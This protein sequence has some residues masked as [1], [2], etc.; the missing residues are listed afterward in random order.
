MEESIENDTVAHELERQLLNN[1][2]RYK[3]KTKLYENPETAICIPLQSND[4]YERSDAF[5]IWSCIY[6]SHL[7]KHTMI[8]LRINERRDTSDILKTNTMDVYKFKSGRTLRGKYLTKR[9][10][11]AWWKTLKTILIE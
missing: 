11:K 10:E 5:H 6:L 1:H 2:K 7:L 3:V 9:K 4:I 8:R